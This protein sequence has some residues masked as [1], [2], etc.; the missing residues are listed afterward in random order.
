MKC[1]RVCVL[2]KESPVN[3]PW[4]VPVLIQ[5]ELT[6]DSRRWAVSRRGP[7]VSVQEAQQEETLPPGLLHHDQSSST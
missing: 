7:P 5:A 2:G 6:L 4:S 3:G 1:L